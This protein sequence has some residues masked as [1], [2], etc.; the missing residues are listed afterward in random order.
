MVSPT[1]QPRMTSAMT[2]AFP[3]RLLHHVVPSARS[4]RQPACQVLTI[5]NSAACLV[6][7]HGPVRACDRRSSSRRTRLAEPNQTGRPRH[8]DYHTL[9]R[10][11][12]PRPGRTLRPSLGG[13]GYRPRES[14]LQ[15]AAHPSITP[16]PRLMSTTRRTIVPA[17]TTAPCPHTAVD[18]AAPHGPRSPPAPKTISRFT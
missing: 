15:P 16:V 14:R 9:A 4:L 7:R 12:T 10:R 1:A 6:I 3:L 13:E 18:L 11:C 5:I 17:Q 8:R 2:S